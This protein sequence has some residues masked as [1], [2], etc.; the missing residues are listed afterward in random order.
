MNIKQCCISFFCISVAL[1]I[2]LYLPHPGCDPVAGFIVLAPRTWSRFLSS[3]FIGASIV[4]YDYMT[5]G[6]G[7]WTLVVVAAYFLIAAACNYVQIGSSLSMLGLCARGVIVTLA[8]DALTGLTVGPLLY[9]QPFMEA[10]VGQI[11]FSIAHLIG[12]S[13]LMIGYMMVVILNARMHGMQ[14]AWLS[15][16]ERKE[17]GY[18]ANNA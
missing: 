4:L 10:V 2:K 18:E 16:S 17:I 12:N 5:V 13:L 1:L 14:C 8:F 7:L 11:P 15:R 9:G 3:V 6:C